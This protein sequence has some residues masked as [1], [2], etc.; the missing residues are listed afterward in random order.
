MS[1]IPALNEYDAINTHTP[2]FNVVPSSCRYS[3]CLFPSGFSM[4]TFC[5]FFFPFVPT[6]RPP[7]IP[8]CG[9]P[10]CTT[11]N[12]ACNEAPCYAILPI[13]LLHRLFKHGCGVTTLRR[14]KEDKWLPL[15]VTALFRRA[16]VPASDHPCVF[17]GWSFTFVSWTI[18]VISPT[19]F[20]TR[21]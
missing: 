9:Q 4:R 8:L 7:H 2:H 5:V 3:R 15:S 17:W 1:L 12:S 11:Q 10:T 13:V 14:G 18:Q 16:L 21:S 6:S 20:W 19:I